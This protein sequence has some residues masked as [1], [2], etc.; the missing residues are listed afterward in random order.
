MIRMYI[1]E[2]NGGLIKNE[3]YRILNTRLSGL[4]LVSSLKGDYHVEC[5]Q[6]YFVDIDKYIQDHD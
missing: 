1:G 3:M 4:C 5:N 2:T 6:K